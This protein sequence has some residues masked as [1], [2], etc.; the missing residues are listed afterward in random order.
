LV[1]KIDVV[2]CTLNSDFI[3]E[4]CLDS[5]YSHIPICHLIVIDGFSEDKTI[6]II[7]N[8]ND[9]YGNVKIIQTE[10]KLGKSREIGIKKVDSEW[11][12]FIDSDVILKS[13]WFEDIFENVQND[14]GA[15]ESN[16]IHYLPE[17]SPIFPGFLKNEPSGYII[18]RQN[19]GQRGYTIATL[20]KTSSVSDLKIPEDLQIYEDEYL[21]RWIEKQGLKWIKAENPIVD[22]FKE[23]ATNFRDAYLTGEYSIKYKLYPTSN[24]ILGFLIF[25]IKFF[26]FLYKY[27]SIEISINVVKHNFYMFKGMLY[28]IMYKFR[29]SFLI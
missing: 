22:H 15:V 24:I 3:L 11:F 16:F 5:L 4:E 29:N 18:H 13:G 7:E 23:N 17:N 2:L 19:N 12:A 21:K 27:N 26:Y 10:A 1:N 8:F 20:V 6:G 25:P 14:V 9:K 28:G